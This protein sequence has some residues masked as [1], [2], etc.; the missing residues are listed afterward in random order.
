M[1]EEAGNGHETGNDQ[2]DKYVDMSKMSKYR[3]CKRIK[4]REDI[5]SYQI[6]KDEKDLPGSGRGGL[7]PSTHCW[8]PY[9][10]TVKAIR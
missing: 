7:C 1:E 6:G 9:L 4:C 10:L 8:G 3:R 5:L 2:M